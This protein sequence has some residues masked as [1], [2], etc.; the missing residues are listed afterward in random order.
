MG[1]EPVGDAT[2]TYDRFAGIRLEFLV[3]RGRVPKELGSPRH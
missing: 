3:G 2:P 1:A